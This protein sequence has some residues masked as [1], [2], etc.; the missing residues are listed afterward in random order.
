MNRDQWYTLFTESQERFKRLQTGIVGLC[1]WE[2]YDPS[3]DSEHPPRFKLE[4]WNHEKFG[5]II[6]QFWPDGNGF[7]TY[8]HERS[9][10]PVWVLTISHRHG[11]DITLY[12][13]EEDARIS[14]R[15][16]V[17]E[18]WHEELEHRGE[19]PK[20]IEVTDEDVSEYFERTMS[21]SY[22]IELKN[23]SNKPL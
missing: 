23:V 22:E 21:E 11:T 12:H 3:A 8:I 16:Y 10:I 20:K 1:N 7:H 19:R 2:C 9:E 18:W 5:A 13:K 6:I 14:I 17:W 4:C 15:N